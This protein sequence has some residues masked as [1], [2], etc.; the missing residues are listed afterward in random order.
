[1]IGF[2]ANRTTRAILE[3]NGVD[4]GKAKWIGRGVGVMVSLMSCEPSGFV[5]VPDIP[6]N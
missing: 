3:R 5:D 4:K 2:I 6:G 1:M